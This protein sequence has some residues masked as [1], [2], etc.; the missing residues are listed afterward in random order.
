[1]ML[2]HVDWGEKV[3]GTSNWNPVCHHSEISCSLL[4]TE[5]DSWEPGASLYFP[6]FIIQIWGNWSSCAEGMNKYGLLIMWMCMFKLK[7]PKRLL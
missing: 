2:V 6:V 4:Y 1:M 5:F 3:L 7:M